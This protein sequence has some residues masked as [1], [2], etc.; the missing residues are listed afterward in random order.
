V[1]TERVRDELAQLAHTYGEVPFVADSRMRIG[2]FANVLIKPNAREAVRAVDPHARWQGDGDPD[3]ER[4]R[5]LIESAGARLYERNGQPV[6]LTLGS[7]GMLAFHSEG[8]TLA[9]AVPP[10]GPMD[11]VGAG[12][13][14]TAGITCAL[15]AGASAAEAAEIGCLA[16][17][18]TIR[19]VGTTGTASRKQIMELQWER[20]R[21]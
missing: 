14:A 7:H 18:V 4:D 19:Q 6:F 1:V 20:D 15:C 8:P 21:S 2:Q 16:A 9:P 11:I 10:R 13:A 17:G 12:D 3:W 5:E